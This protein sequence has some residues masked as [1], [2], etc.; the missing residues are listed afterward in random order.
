MRN[1]SYIFSP[2]IYV[3]NTSLISTVY[4][5]TITQLMRF[6]LDKWNLIN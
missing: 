3:H 2:K 1:L 5:P 4:A 6:Q